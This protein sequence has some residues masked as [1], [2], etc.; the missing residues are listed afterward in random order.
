M[1]S[2][3]WLAC[4]IIAL[5]FPALALFSSVILLVPSSFRQCSTR[6]RR[7]REKRGDF[8]RAPLGL[9]SRYTRASKAKGAG[10]KTAT[11]LHPPSASDNYHVKALAKIVPCP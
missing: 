1:L 4:C 9:S 5:S 3:T 6:L 10:L 8:Q 11:L 2:A 7:H